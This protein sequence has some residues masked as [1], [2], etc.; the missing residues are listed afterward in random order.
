[1]IP[2]IFKDFL[3]NF[4]KSNYKYDKTDIR[5]AYIVDFY[6]IDKAKSI[7]MAPKLAEK[8]IIFPNVM[9]MRVNLSAEILSHSV[10]A[11]INTLCALGH[12]PDEVSATA[13]CI[14]T[15]DQLFNAFYGAC[16]TSSQKYK[17]ALSDNSGHISFPN[18][19]LQFLSKV[20]GGGNTV[21][22]CIVG[23]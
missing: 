20:K 9:A 19:Y 23:W 22:P 11:N 10:A 2:H 15:F 14:Q 12:L 7:Q 5:W 4:M 18:S 17:N 3:N 8:H 13:E 21:V 16:L 6:N 1:M